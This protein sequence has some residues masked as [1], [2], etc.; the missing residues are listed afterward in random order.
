MYCVHIHTI[1][2]EWNSTPSALHWAIDFKCWMCTHTVHRKCTEATATLNSIWS[3]WH[4]VHWFKLQY[5]WKLVTVQTLFNHF[6]ANQSNSQI[7]REE[8][9]NT[10]PNQSAKQI[11]DCV[12]LLIFR[13][14]IQA[15]LHHSHQTFPALHSNDLRSR[16][17]CEWD[18]FEKIKLKIKTITNSFGC[19][20]K[21]K[22][23][24]AKV[25]IA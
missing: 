12:W 8:K 15:I 7:R 1:G 17:K 14:A 11:S 25:R 22:K 24:N 16:P 4:T 2:N 6:S 18:C 9:K 20:E 21:K 19:K 5:V 10:H 3:N 13:K 23:T